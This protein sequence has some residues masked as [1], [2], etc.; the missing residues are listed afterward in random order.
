MSSAKA[1]KMRSGP[2]RPCVG[3][4]GRRRVNLCIV[5][6]LKSKIGTQ[7]QKNRFFILGEFQNLH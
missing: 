4:P 5:I 3:T 1:S 7:L 2:A 6:V